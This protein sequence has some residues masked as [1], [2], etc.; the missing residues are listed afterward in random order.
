MFN[1]P[2]HFILPWCFQP[3]R[4]LKLCEIATHT[5]PILRYKSI[6][7]YQNAQ[8]HSENQSGP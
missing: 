4:L 8:L 6:I 2:I 1:V 3:P 7:S 5:F